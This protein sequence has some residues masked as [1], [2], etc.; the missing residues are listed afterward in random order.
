LTR[1]AEVGEEEVVGVLNQVARALRVAQMGLAEGGFE[2][3]VAVHK[4][5]KKEQNKKRRIAQ[6]QAQAQA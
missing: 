6:A 5:R 4:D 3:R 2:E 1:S